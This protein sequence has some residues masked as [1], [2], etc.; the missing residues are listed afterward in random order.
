MM[1]VTDCLDARCNPILRRGQAW[2]VTEDQVPTTVPCLVSAG[3]REAI[4]VLMKPLISAAPRVD[5]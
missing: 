1:T 3:D 4:T 5:V 2:R